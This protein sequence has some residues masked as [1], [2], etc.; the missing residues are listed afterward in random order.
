MKKGKPQKNFKNHIKG[1]LNALN[2]MTAFFLIVI[3]A[4]YFLTDYA[5]TTDSPQYIQYL[6]LTKE[7]AA[8]MHHQLTLPFCAFMLIFILPGLVKK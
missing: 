4:L 6:N 1:F 8:Y 3:T 2:T 5:M 7:T